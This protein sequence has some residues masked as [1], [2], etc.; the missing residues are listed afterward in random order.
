MPTRPG[1]LAE[2]SAASIPPR[3]LQHGV[4][5]IEK[6]DYLQQVGITAV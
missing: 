4:T 3:A 2:T 1:A 6:D 5:L